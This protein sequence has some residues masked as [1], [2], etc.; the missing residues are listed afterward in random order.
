MMS[1]GVVSRR[2]EALPGER[3]IAR[4]KIAR[5]AWQV[6]KQLEPLCAGDCERAQFV[7][8]DML[9]RQDHHV[10]HDLVL[11]RQH[12]GHCGRVAAIRHVQH[13]GAGQHLEE[14]AGKMRR[15]VRRRPEAMLICAGIAL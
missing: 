4:H 1:G 6:G 10:E 2:H 14:L 11:P 3:L 15:R 9:L 7:R 5:S 13:V 8:F 12:V